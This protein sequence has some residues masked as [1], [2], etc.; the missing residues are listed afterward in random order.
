MRQGRKRLPIDVPT[1]FRLWNDETLRIEDVALKM[2]VG[3]ATLRKWAAAHGLRTRVSP[4][5]VVEFLDCPSP[6]EDLL[7]Q[8]SLALSPWVEARARECRERHYAERRRE[9]VHASD[10]RASRQRTGNLQ[11]AG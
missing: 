4:P 5:T 10:N 7:S 3:V 1:L 2:N 6:A 11:E 9:T 8:D